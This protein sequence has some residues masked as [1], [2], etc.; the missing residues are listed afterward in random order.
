[1]HHHLG[2][3]TF[4][5]STSLFL[6]CSLVL[7]CS[8]DRL[9][10]LWA[11]PPWKFPSQ[12]NHTNVKLFL[13]V[14]IFP[15]HK[16]EIDRLLLQSF[17][18]IARF[19]R[20]PYQ[21]DCHLPS[22]STPRLSVLVS[23]SSTTASSLRPRLPQ[24]HHHRQQLFPLGTPACVR[25]RG[26]G[27][28][29]PPSWS[30]ISR[31]R[32]EM[33]PALCPAWVTSGHSPATRA[34]LPQALMWH[35][36]VKNLCNIYNEIFKKR[37]QMPCSIQLQTRSLLQIWCLWVQVLSIRLCSQIFF[38]FMVRHSPF[39]KCCPRCHSLSFQWPYQAGPIHHLK[40]VAG[41]SRKKLQRK[42]HNPT[43]PKPPNTDA[44]G[45][46]WKIEQTCSDVIYL[47]PIQSISWIKLYYLI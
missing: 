44:K 22:F 32:G 24:H 31:G 4:F 27:Q 17:H 34:A 3:E 23:Q 5:H 47:S 15:P 25:A 12:E 7:S 28:G 46:I 9:C 43:P 37:M 38:C 35:Y 6:C 45:A 18:C 8:P 10:L 11:N 33:C 2:G 21:S 42:N 20:V 36:L 13:K 26:A 29:V 19:F 40:T 14:C 16:K 41:A 1:M 30:Y 39:W